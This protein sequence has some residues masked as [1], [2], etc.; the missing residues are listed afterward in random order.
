MNKLFVIV[1]SIAPLLVFGDVATNEV[2]DAQKDAKRAAMKELMLKKNGGMIRVKGEG[3]ILI[4]N[5]QSRIDDAE[6][7][8]RVD[9][10]SQTLK[11][12]FEITRG[13]WKFGDPRPAGSDAAIFLVD[14]SALPMSVV[15]VEPRWGVVNTATLK[16]GTRFTKELTRVLTLTLGSAVSQF[17]A[18]SLQPVEKSSDLD[19]LLTDGFTPDM[20]NSIFKNMKHFGVSR[21]AFMTYRKACELGRA[22]APSNKYQQAIWDE[23]YSIPD[24]PLTIKK[25]K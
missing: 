16:L 4:V 8:K 5:C 22:P 18:S 21:N 6:I 23:V 13:A 25:Q 14:D 24:K 2:A 19:A 15:A 9:E 20:A 17:P 12:N 1:S 10:F 11:F 7:A 3:K